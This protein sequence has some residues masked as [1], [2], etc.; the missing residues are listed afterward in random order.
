MYCLHYSTDGYGSKLQE[1]VGGCD[2][3]FGC[4]LVITVTRALVISGLNHHCN[5]PLCGTALTNT[6]AHSLAAALASRGLLGPSE[7]AR[8]CLGCGCL[9]RERQG[10]AET[11]T[12]K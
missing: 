2:C 10:T 1:R 4:I 11:G 7:G 8:Q 12:N 3:V 6:A 5:V 9:S